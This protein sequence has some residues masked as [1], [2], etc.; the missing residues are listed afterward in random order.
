MKIDN[1]QYFMLSAGCKLVDGYTR[2]AIIDYGRGDL[3]FISH[4]YYTLLQKM[5]RL[6]IKDIEKE[7]DSDSRIHFY[8]FLD[9]IL[10]N[11]LGFFADDP[12]K[13]PVM[14][15]MPEDDYIELQDVII[16]IDQQIFDLEIF[17]KLCD[18]LKN[19]R[20]K[21]FQI[22]LLSTADLKFLTT[23]VD[24]IE[25]TNCNYIEIHCMFNPDITEDDLS[26]FVEKH[27]LVSH[28]YLYGAPF[29]RKKEV[30][31]SIPGFHSLALGCLYYLNYSFDEGNCCG[32]INM[33]NL[34]FSSIYVH[35]K[36]K[37]RNGCLDK[38][39]SI[40]RFGNIKNCPSMSQVYGNVQDTSI[41]EI[42]GNHD[43]RK[44]W[45]IKKDQISVCKVC[46]FRY[47]CTDCRAF[48]N[49]STDMYG[50]PAKCGYDPYTGKWKDHAMHTV[51]HKMNFI[52]DSK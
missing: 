1:E 32:I 2:C 45:F 23:I 41:N 9:F 24:I 52:Q 7:L 25:T 26:E 6:K 37:T 48:T 44:Y 47:S 33:G 14:S 11:E 3:Y 29:I 19:L 10:E 8:N 27:V 50:K 46:E 30:M 4:D 42:I 51:K 28:F 39:I 16:E 20:C 5:D 21:D 31:N 43:F 34:N 35:N 38:K 49:D 15:E 12:M 36:L 17:L 40:D 22:R 13:F 18:D